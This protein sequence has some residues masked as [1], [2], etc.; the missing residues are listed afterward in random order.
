[1]ERYVIY[2]ICI[3]NLSSWRGWSNLKLAGS[4]EQI[5]LDYRHSRLV[6]HILLL[7]VITIFTY[8]ATGLYPGP[9]GFVAPS[10]SGFLDLILYHFGM[11]LYVFQVFS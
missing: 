4:R 7:L 8:P 2:I 9:D 6:K 11:F 5:S 3:Y 10:Y 1:M